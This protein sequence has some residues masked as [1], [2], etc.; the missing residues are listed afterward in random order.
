MPAKVPNVAWKCEHCGKRVWL[1]PAAAKTR[2]YCSRECLYA[3][4][5]VEHP[6]REKQG[7][8]LARYGE[9]QC[10]MCGTTFEAK[11]QSQLFCG[12]EC[13]VKNAQAKRRKEQPA[14][15]PCEVCGAVFTPRQGSAGRFCSRK[16][17]FAGQ[18]G[19]ASPL[20]R[21][22]RYTKPD[23]YVMVS[24]LDHPYAQKHHGYVP[25]H[26]LVMEKR[27]GRF[28][29]PHETVHHVNGVRDDNRDENLQLRSGRHGKG[30][31]YRCLDCG[32]HNVVA[33]H[34][35]EETE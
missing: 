14:S 9:R 29:E 34:L 2:R 11:H 1:K 3:G 15:R 26:R 24:V 6:V 17:S 12:Q 5:R 8:R 21:G 18:K 32:S 30:A 31:A 10:A 20:W 23:G 28:L 25:E 16:C 33:V 4:Q 35:E 7:Q 19:T 27:L 13:S 22:G